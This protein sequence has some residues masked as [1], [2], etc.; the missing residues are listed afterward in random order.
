MKG[1]ELTGFPV[2]GDDTLFAKY[3]CHSSEISYF[4]CYL[5][6]THQFNVLN[7]NTNTMLKDSL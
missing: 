3:K 6:E 2:K 5:N 7:L 4:F 1:N